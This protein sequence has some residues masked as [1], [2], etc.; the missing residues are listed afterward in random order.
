MYE[1]F[2]INK[3]PGFTEPWTVSETSSSYFF[4]LSRQA[5]IF[6]SCIS[7]GNVHILLLKLLKLQEATRI[8]DNVIFFIND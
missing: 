2:E 3:S 5:L 4:I 7:T 6:R 1:Y 8:S